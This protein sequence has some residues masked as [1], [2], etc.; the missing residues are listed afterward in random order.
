M[1]ARAPIYLIVFIYSGV[2]I[3]VPKYELAFEHEKPLRFL[4]LQNQQ[5]LNKIIQH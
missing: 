4:Q 2:L 3:A 1:G 5:F